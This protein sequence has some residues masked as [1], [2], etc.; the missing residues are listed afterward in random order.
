MKA[1][2]GLLVLSLIG[3]ALVLVGPTAAQAPLSFWASPM[4]E[5]KAVIIFVGDLMFDRYIRAKA[6]AFGNAHTL[7]G[8][9][10]FLRE[11]DF[12]VGNLEGPVT[13]TTSRSQ[14]TSV[15][16]KD[17]MR[18][19]FPTDTPELLQGYG[20]GLVSL[21]NNHMLDFGREGVEETKRLLALSGIGFVGDPL[22]EAPDIVVKEAGGTR[23][24]F[25]AY[26]DFFGQSPE[27]AR[28]AI[29]E[30]RAILSP[31]AIV[32][33]AHWGEEYA[34]EPPERVR[35]LGRGFIDA[36]ADLVI[37]SHPHVV[38]P[39]EDYRGG[40]IYYSLG[41]FVFDQYWN[42]EVRCGKAV[43]AVFG[44][45]GIAYEEQEIGMEPD[46]RTVLGCR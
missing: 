17:N 42:E 15:G 5:K 36:G 38:Q 28:Q 2:L 23:L 46:G 32:V 4:P 33:L 18:F 14:G 9:A 34:P 31:D 27:D 29:R 10:D 26:N 8:I 39:F 20:F 43:I 19:T 35:A 40:R 21:G 6:E 13:G 44:G 41:N 7:G 25:L 11:A 1:V 30:A 12:V 45:R 37:G 3:A 16:D 22:L 24:A